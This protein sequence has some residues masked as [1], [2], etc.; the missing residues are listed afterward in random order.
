MCQTSKLSFTSWESRYASINN[1]NQFIRLIIRLNTTSPAKQQVWE[2]DRL[3][4][5]ELMTVLDD[6]RSRCAI[7]PAEFT[8]ITARITK[9]RRDFVWHATDPSSQRYSAL[10]LAVQIEFDAIPCIDMDK[11]A[12]KIESNNDAMSIAMAESWAVA[13]RLYG[14][15]TLPEPAIVSW[16]DTSTEASIAYPNLR[17][18]STY[19]SLR[20]MHRTRLLELL[21]EIWGPEDRSCRAWLLIVAGV[22][23]SDGT[24]EDRRFVLDCLWQLWLEP[25]TV[26]SFIHTIEKLRAFWSSGKTSWEDCFYV[27]TESMP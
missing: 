11:W 4:D 26:S 27:P 6:T 22:A 15:L 8:L 13:L 23:V 10:R 24:T 5:D 9:L 25:S 1:S 19:N 20:V 16:L 18:L 7:C 21:R 12:S 2:I 17:G 14:I 3:K